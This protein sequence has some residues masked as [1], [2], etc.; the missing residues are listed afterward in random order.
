LKNEIYLPE[1]VGKGYKDFWNFKGRY[2][3]CKGSRASKKSKTTALRW[4]YLMMK[5]PQ[6]NLL[7]V[8]KY[9]RTLKESC[10]S[11]LKWAIHR[12]KVDAFW[13]IKE[14]P[15]EMCYKPTGQKI[16]FRG[17]DDPLKV[18]SIT[19]DVGV[20]CWGWIE[21]SYE[22]MNE[23]DFNTLD[24]SIRG[25]IPEGLFKQWV[26]TFNPWNS[27][28]W[29]KKRFFDTQSPDVLAKTTNY[30]CNEWLDE[31]DLKLF[32][33]MKRDR[34]ERYR[35]A[36]LGEWGVTEGLIFT[37]WTSA[38]LSAEIPH[39][40][41]IYNGLDFG[42]ADPNALIRI[43]FE[44]GQK[45]IY[46]FD[47]FYQGGI[48]LETLANEV[49]SRIG[50]EYVICDCAGKQQIIEMCRY[51]LKA[52][53]SRKGAGSKL[54]GIQWLQGYDIVVDYRCRHFIEE[55]SEYC[56]TKDRN[57]NNCDIPQDGK[58]HLMDALRYA[59][60]LVQHR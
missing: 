51:G 59:T 29:L 48:S 38:D 24:E 56:W 26:I 20:L 34:P 44:P 21:E 2:N 55:I 1:I 15:L 32:E 33:D 9:F 12:L 41:N 39:F 57:G 11:E 13:N 50:S 43:D 28:H 31:A 25:E 10:F 47:E 14:S 7:V 53:P 5:Y 27:Q 40:A 18:T 35:V 36:G 22:I 8:R 49:K 58:D 6:A 17:L 46:V 60:E 37:N 45:K 42:A 30:L 54:Y 19:V 52:I 3:V 23:S 16:Y 4:I